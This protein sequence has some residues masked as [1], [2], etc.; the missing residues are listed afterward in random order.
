MSSMTFGV[1]QHKL[2]ALAQIMQNYTVAC[3]AQ[4]GGRGVGGGA[5]GGAEGGHPPAG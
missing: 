3:R 2:F 4:G 1:L 5:G